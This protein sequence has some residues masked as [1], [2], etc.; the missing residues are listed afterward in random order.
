M[1]PVQNRSFL[2]AIAS[3]VK[4]LCLLIINM[5]EVANNGVAMAEKQVKAARKQ[6]AIDLGIRMKDYAQRAREHAAMQ[7]VKA[8]LAMREFIG[9]DPER[10]QLVEQARARIDAVIAQELAELEAEKSQNSIF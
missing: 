5:V 9:G 2:G 7:E 4:A 3:A 1:N 10:Q 6:Q 8:E